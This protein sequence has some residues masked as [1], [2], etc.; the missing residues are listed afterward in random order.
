MPTR[1]IVWTGVSAAVAAI[2]VVVSAASASC[3][4][5]T[6]YTQCMRFTV[7][8]ANQVFTVPPG[9]SSVQIRLWGGGGG[10]I[11]SSYWQP[12]FGGG[13][14]GFAAGTVSVV[15]GESLNLTVARGGQA[16]SIAGGTLGTVPVFGGGGAGGVGSLSNG[17]DGARGGANGSSGGGLSAVWRGA[18]FTVGNQVLIAGGGGG[19]SNGSEG[20]DAAGFF[21]VAGGGGGLSGG[22]SAVDLNTNGAGGTQ[23]AAGAAATDTAH[24]CQI[25]QTAGAQFQGGTGAS[26]AD[27]P[28]WGEGGGGGGGGWFGGGGGRCQP[29]DNSAANGGGGGGSAFIAGSGVTAGAT[30]AGANASTASSGGQAANAA[31]TQYVAGVGLG[32]ADTSANTGD[33]GDGLIVIQWSV[34]PAAVPTAIPVDSAWMLAL[35]SLSLGL[36]GAWHRRRCDSRV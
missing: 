6:P 4:P 20:A 12:S 16:G 33:G 8:G 31:D 2:P 10:G 1:N 22:D 29:K 34:S 23:T 32:G 7:S 3:T 21:G 9:V 15:A 36:G 30:Q 13:G 24:Y 26:N 18:P 19:A 35:L 5:D 11:S 14:G 17:P 27:S 28:G 25:Y